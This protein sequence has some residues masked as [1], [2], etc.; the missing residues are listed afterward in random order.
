MNLELIRQNERAWADL[1]DL[2]T[3]YSQGAGADET[4]EINAELS[5]LVDRYTLSTDAFVVR[6]NELQQAGKLKSGIYKALVW[7]YGR[8]TKGPENPQGLLLADHSAE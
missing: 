2:I 7:W 6:L 5:Q 4:E 1:Q 8:W 3:E